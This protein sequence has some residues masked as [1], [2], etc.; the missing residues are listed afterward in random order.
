MQLP[1]IVSEDSN[2]MMFSS[3]EEALLYLEPKD[4]EKGKYVAYDAQGSSLLLAVT[5]VRQSLFGGQVDEV[6]FDDSVGEN[7]SNELQGKLSRFFKSVQIKNDSD[8]LPNMVRDLE[9][10][11]WNF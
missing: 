11:M 9:E 3:A 5:K 8:D 4:V 1:I 10:V 7:K 6:V 2:I